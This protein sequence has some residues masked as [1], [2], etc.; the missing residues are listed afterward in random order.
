[1]QVPKA[2]LRLSLK[3]VLFTT[4]FTSASVAALPYVTALAGWYGAKIVVVHCV[5]PEPVLSMPMEPMPQDM[6][7][8]W[9]NAKIKMGEFL[10]S[11]PLEGTAHE[12]LVLQGDLWPVLEDVIR[13]HEIDLIVLGTHGREGIKKLVM[14]S[15]AEQ[16]FRRA[17]CP[18]LT[19]GPKAIHPSVRFENWKHI[20]FA[21][22]FSAGSLGALPYALS[23]A[24]ENQAALTLLHMISLVPMQR[25]QFVIEAARKRL[26]LLVPLEAAAWCNPE[27]VVQLGFPTDGILR[28]AEERGA[29]LIV[30]GVHTPRSPRASVHLPWAIA[31]EVVSRSHCPVLTVRG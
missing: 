4:D 7:F 27:F 11:R 20:L 1:M 31:H 15:S 26:E 30:M 21:T 24:E 23:L 9:R 16:I 17:A 5:E 10:R 18:V 25:E 22:D 8:N 3:N 12:T 29:D 6:D 19:V 14:G 28:V 2:N 13:R